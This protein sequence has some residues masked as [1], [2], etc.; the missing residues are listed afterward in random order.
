LIT[1][2]IVRLRRATEN[3]SGVGDEE[4][5]PSPRVVFWLVTSLR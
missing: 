2:E 5:E 3:S 1:I 4:I